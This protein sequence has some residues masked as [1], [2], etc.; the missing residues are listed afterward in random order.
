MADQVTLTVKGLDETISKSESDTGELTPDQ[1]QEADSKHIK[2]L[3]STLNTYKKKFEHKVPR[4][5]ANSTGVQ[6]VNL[7]LSVNLDK[8]IKQGLLEELGLP[9]KPMSSNGYGSDLGY[10]FESQML[11]AFSRKGAEALAQE[12]YEYDMT[13]SI[14][15]KYKEYLVEYRKELKTA[16]K[17]L[18]DYV[19]TYEGKRMTKKFRSRYNDQV[20]ILEGYVTKLEEKV[21]AT[22]AKTKDNFVQRKAGRDV[23]KLN[24]V[25]ID[26]AVKIL[27]KLTEIRGDKFTLVSNSFIVSDR[28]SD[29]LLFWFMPTSSYTIIN[30]LS[31]FNFI[32]D[33][34]DYAWSRTSEGSD[35]MLS[36]GLPTKLMNRG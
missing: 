10:I 23:K 31:S 7:P 26:T 25:Y 16:K 15:A 28:N 8:P 12:D 34:W 2:D 29:I 30:S 24:L 14:E 4:Q 17:E 6:V 33:N 3:R 21:A 9:I 27:A 1:I 20:M 35:E 5:L 19:K 13:N 32:V 22:Q 36:I 18:K 11:L